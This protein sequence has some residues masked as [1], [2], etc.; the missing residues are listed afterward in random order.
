MPAGTAHLVHVPVWGLCRL[1]TT[2]WRSLLYEC[3]LAPISRSTHVCAWKLYS[4]EQKLL[5]FDEITKAL[6]APAPWLNVLPGFASRWSLAWGEECQNSVLRST[7]NSRAVSL[8]LSRKIIKL[9]SKAMAAHFS[10]H[11]WAMCAW[12]TA[13]VNPIN[14]AI[15]ASHQKSV[16]SSMAL[17]VAREKYSKKPP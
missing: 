7:S 11:R 9:H 8:S 17:F 6:S 16:Y 4:S 10:E 5:C 2:S 1:K 12:V 15:C 13:R 3:N 14:T